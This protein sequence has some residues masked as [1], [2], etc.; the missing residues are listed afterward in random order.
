[1]S[2]T[3][4]ITLIRNGNILHAAVGEEVVMMSVESG[5]YFGLNAVASRIWELLESPKT[6]SGLCAQICQEFEIDALT[7]E[8]EV[9]KFVGELIDRS[10]LCE[11]PA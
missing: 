6:V 9:L 11:V 10:L 2:I 8:T 4:E 7:C 3:P 1:M 5:H